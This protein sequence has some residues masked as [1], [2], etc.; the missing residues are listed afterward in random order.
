MAKREK[1]YLEFV[2]SRNAAYR[3]AEK[4]TGLVTVTVPHTGLYNRM[5]QKFFHTPPYSD[6]DLDEF[7]SFVWKQIDG[8]RSVYEIAALVKA[9]FGDRAEP[10][11]PRLVEFFKIL[12]NNRFVSF[13]KDMKPIAT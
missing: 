1:N 3:W 6:I 4:E 5:A 10:L 8:E 2:P 11:Y 7:G 13:A 9:A 12:K